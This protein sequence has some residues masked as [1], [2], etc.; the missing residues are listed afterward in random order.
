M[1]FE[2]HFDNEF[3]VLLHLSNKGCGNKPN[4]CLMMM[5]MMCLP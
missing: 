4:M 5:M 3:S 2:L 1:D